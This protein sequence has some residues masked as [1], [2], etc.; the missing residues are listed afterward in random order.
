MKRS[1][2]YILILVVAGMFATSCDDCDPVSEPAPERGVFRT[3]VTYAIGENDSI[4]NYE[5][6]VETMQ[7]VNKDMDGSESFITLRE[8]AFDWG[9]RN[10]YN[11]RTDLIY[12]QQIMP[13]KYR[14]F[15][16]FISQAKANIH[17][18]GH[19]DPAI[20]EFNLDFSEEP[21]VIEVDLGEHFEMKDGDMA[22]LY[23]WMDIN[24]AFPREIEDGEIV[25]VDFVPELSDSKFLYA[26]R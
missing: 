7:L 18:M 9:I 24:Q 2:P 17:P 26:A 1:L 10:S 15:R 22:D 6:R 19:D 8:Q 14:Y 3:W 4:E 20:T 13:G 21:R 5:L 23:L 25:S 16:M 11:D 12:N